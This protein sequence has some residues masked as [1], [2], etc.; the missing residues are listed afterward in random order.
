MKFW[1]GHYGDRIYNL[2]YDNLT[3][4]QEDETRK[5]IRHVGLDWEDGC[6]SPQNNQ[7]DVFTASYQQVR[8]KV[9]QGSSQQWRKFEPYLNGAFDQLN[10]LNWP[11]TY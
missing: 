1:Q 3:T 8:H 7:R 9:Y 6:L 2:N 11:I 5:L 10:V 4:N